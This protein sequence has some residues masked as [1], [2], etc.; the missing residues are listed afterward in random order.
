MNNYE[1][2]L[3]VLSIN[4]KCEKYYYTNSLKGNHYNGE[5]N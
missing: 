5:V 2:Y 4:M 3:S 1:K